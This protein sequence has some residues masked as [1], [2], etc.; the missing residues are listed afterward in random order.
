MRIDAMEVMRGIVADRAAEK[1]FDPEEARDESG[2]WTGAI[3]NSGVARRGS[4]DFEPIAGPSGYKLHGYTWEYNLLEYVDNSGEDRVKKVS[5]WER[6]EAADVTGRNIVH[7]F[8]VTTPDNR[9]TTVSLETAAKLLGYG[10]AT[11]G[12]KQIKSL[13]SAAK[14]LAKLQMEKATI[15]ADNARHAEMNARH[16]TDMAR[17]SREVKQAPIQYKPNAVKE[18]IGKMTLDS[19]EV[20]YH[21]RDMPED[22]KTRPWERAEFER[23]AK[24]NDKERVDTLHRGA[25]HKRMLALGHEHGDNPYHHDLGDIPERIKRAEAKI[26]VVDKTMQGVHS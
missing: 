11:E 25:I 13:A 18:G 16:V 1:G 26:K 5:A 2:K 10:A 12:G 8:N 15:E 20:W 22:L 9:E 4:V 14:T 7:K 3:K 17:V 21:H 19:D 6:A 23:V 24:L